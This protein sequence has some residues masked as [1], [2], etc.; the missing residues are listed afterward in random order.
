M[1]SRCRRENAVNGQSWL[2]CAAQCKLIQQSVKC[3][4]VQRRGQNGFRWGEVHFL[5]ALFFIGPNLGQ[6]GLGSILIQKCE[7]HSVVLKVLECN[8]LEVQEKEKKKDILLLSMLK[9]FRCSPAV[10]FVN[11]ITEVLL[12]HLPNWQ[13]QLKPS[14]C[15]MTKKNIPCLFSARNIEKL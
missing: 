2:L 4:P 15:V 9:L 12:F 5:F 3:R 13:S 11:T 14:H 10:Y 8:L 6:G 7:S 1:C